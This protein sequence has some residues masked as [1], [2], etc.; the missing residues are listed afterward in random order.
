VV[1][2]V[3]ATVK[4]MLA[5][6][7][8]KPE[9]IPADVITRI[10]E[11]ARLTGSSRNRQQWDFV[12]VQQKDALQKLGELASTGSYLRDAPLAI[13][14]VT[15]EA[16]VGYIDG[17]RAAQD[18]MLVAWEEGVGSNWVGNMNR[19]EVKELLGV[20]QEKM[21]LTVLAFGY[22]AKKIG[23]GKKTRKALS[24]IAHAERFGNAYRA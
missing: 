19:P 3:F 24:E 8:Y 21:V 20:P 17:A 11:A 13:A 18:M 1:V 7:E 15:P 9:A 6:R 14:V 23:A 16:P 22:P 2:K 12:V 10:L 5:V 4:S